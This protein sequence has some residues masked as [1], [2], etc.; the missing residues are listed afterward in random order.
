[1]RLAEP[2]GRLP[3]GVAQPAYDR[4]ALGRAIVHLGLG[5][6]ARAHLAAVNEAAITASGDLR[7]GIVGV[8]MRHPQ[9]RDALAPQHGLYAL[10]L[11]DAD[12]DGHARETLQVI[13]CV[14]AV[15][16]AP[17]DPRAVLER[18][19][20]PQTRIVSLTVTEKGYCHDPASGA[21]RFD[22]VDI[23]HDLGHPASPRSAIGFIAHGL[24]LRQQRGLAG[25]TL[26]S[27]DNLPSNGRT[28]RGLVGAFAGRLDPA[29]AGWIDTTCRF[30]NA[31]VDRIVPRTTEADRTGIS[32]RLGLD[33]AAPVVAEPFLDWVIEDDF[34]AGRPAW[35]AGGA[36]FVAQALPHERMKLRML[37]G[38]HST[39]AY[40]GG[41]AGLQTVHEVIGV[42]DLRAF[43]DAL[44]R[45]EIAPTLP[46]DAGLDADAYRLRLLERFGNPSLGH[47]TRQI[48]MDGSQ[49]LPQRLL[50]TARDRLA[51][52]LPIERIALAVAAWIRYLEGSDEHG[53]R[54]EIDDPLREVLALQLLAARSAADAHEDEAV[55]RR[56]IAA[57]CTYAPV[58]GD[59]GADPRFIDAVARQ[60]TR[61]RQH[62]AVDA[63]RRAT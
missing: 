2:L 57:F 53:N 62:G 17:E 7:W 47:R 13:G 6:F 40:L 4:H 1:M 32:A 33:D 43:I 49:K 5:A 30:P 59:L 29:L 22:D 21:L 26:L 8:S 51:A 20:D 14:R 10:A 15:L 52:G 44:M 54:H 42:A 45:C 11:R 16:V 18:I 25:V 23:A 3:D 27:C 28:L 46:A 41:L 12:A 61:L 48:A 63:A 50:G 39:I 55:E 37:N 60:S 36:R 31:M 24:H 35:Q 58:F 19:A 9:V 56:R 34:A 38:S